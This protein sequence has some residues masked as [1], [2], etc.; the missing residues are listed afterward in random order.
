MLTNVQAKQQDAQTEA[1]L[2]A[3]FEALRA[4]G[5]MPD[6]SLGARP[7]GL[8]RRLVPVLEML[9]RARAA[10]EPVVWERN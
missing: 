7:V 1:Q 3:N 10:G 6:A 4:S 5:A 9:E 8:S 2:E